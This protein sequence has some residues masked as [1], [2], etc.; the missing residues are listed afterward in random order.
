MITESVEDSLFECPVTISNLVSQAKWIPSYAGFGGFSYREPIISTST[1]S[2]LFMATN[3]NSVRS[4][5]RTFGQPDANAAAEQTNEDRPK[6]DVWINV[7][8]SVA[9]P[10]TT[11]GAKKG[12]TV[13]KFIGV[14]LG[15]ALDTQ[16]EIDTSKTRSSELMEIQTYQNQLLH[17]LQEHAKTL[18]PGEEQI[19]TLEV[20]LRRVNA[21]IEAPAADGNSAYARPAGM[22]FVKA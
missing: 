12:D 4:F 8:Y 18:A 14:P 5:A 7:G 3:N 22:G 1:E 9:V 21:P 15:I 2:V 16:R 13:N 19:L 6:A 10:D 11:E 17:D 20:Q